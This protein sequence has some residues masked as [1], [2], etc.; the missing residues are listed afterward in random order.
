MH[1]KDT[2]GTTECR[3]YSDS[4]LAMGSIQY[5][6]C[7]DLSALKLRIITV[8]KLPNWFCA[9]DIKMVSPWGLF[10]VAT[11]QDQQ[12]DLGA[13]RRLWSA[14]ASAQSDQSLLCAQWTAKTLIRMDGCPRWSES[15]LGV[16]VI[17]LVLSCTGSVVYILH[18]NSYFLNTWFN[19]QS[20][21]TGPVCQSALYEIHTYY[22][23]IYIAL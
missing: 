16:Q 23:V 15:S 7:T 10:W 14:W 4:D 5:I 21:C 2:D 3:P 11:W 9:T 12:N 13:Q 1:P 22:S 18:S 8:T 20:T 6:I 17:L 19:L